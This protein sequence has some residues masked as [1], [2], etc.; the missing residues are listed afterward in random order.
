MSSSTGIA[1]S[2]SRIAPTTAAQCLRT[3]STTNSPSSAIRCRST[4]GSPNSPIGS[5]GGERAEELADR[6]GRGEDRAE[7]A[8]YDVGRIF[9]AGDHVERGEHDDEREDDAF[10]P[11]HV[12]D[13]LRER[14]I[15]D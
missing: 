3:S 8:L 13:S 9:G 14:R 2:A 7:C 1:A 12:Q 6:L 5:G 4:R 15:A 11:L 10:D